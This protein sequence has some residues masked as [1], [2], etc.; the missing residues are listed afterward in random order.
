MEPQ[1]KTTAPARHEV[2]AM[3]GDVVVSFGTNWCGYC[4]AAEPAIHEA[5]SARPGLTH[6]RVEDG[7]GRPLGRS[8]QVK[9]W[10]TLI[11][12]KNGQELSRI[13]RPKNAEEI[14][15]ALGALDEAAAR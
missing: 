9:L 12:M 2:D 15:L 11:V 13:V 14:T 5:I 4:Q 6:I 3:R 7:P 8:F 10:P 1:Y